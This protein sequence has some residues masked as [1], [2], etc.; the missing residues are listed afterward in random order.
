MPAQLDIRIVAH[1]AASGVL[2]RIGGVVD[3]LGRFGLAAAGLRQIGDA[4]DGLTVGVKAA[5]DLQQAVANISTIKPE[6]D[7]TAVFGALN[8]MSTRVPQSSA[9][10]GESLYNVFSSMSVSSQEALALVETFAQGAVGAQ[11]D[12]ATFGTSIMGVLNAY[13]LAASDAARVSD[14]FFNTVNAG[15]VTGQELA[16]SL[17]PVTQAAKSAGMSVDELGGFIAGVT[18]EGGPAAQNINNLSNF[19]QKL[20]TKEAQKQLNELGVQTVDATGKFRPTTDVLE[21]LKGKLGGMTEAAKANALQAIFPDA[22]AR[23]GAQTLLSQ[24]EFVRGAIETNV[25]QAG[26]ASSAYATMAAT[27]NSQTQL[28]TNTLMSIAVTVGAQVLPAVTPLVS[29]FAAALPGAFAATSAALAPLGAVLSTLAQYLLVVVQ[30][31]DYLN[32]F[33]ADLPASV[34]PVVQLLGQGLAGAIEVLP[35][36]FA[37]L[38]DVGGQVAGFLGEH[39]ELIAGVVAAW[40]TFGVLSTVVGWI[41]SAVA[42]WGA[43]SV[44]VTAAGGV[45]AAIVAVLGGPITVAVLAVAAVV[46]VLTAAWIGNWGDIQG[47]TAAVVEFLGALPETLVGYWD[48]IVGGVQGLVDGVTGAWDAVSE[49]TT[50][51]W[52]AI[53]AFLAE[54]WDVLLAT[55]IGGP[56]GLL[57]ALIARNWDTIAEATSAAW[58]AIQDALR[59]VWE[60]IPADIRAD[61]ELILSTLIER[62]AAWVE[63]VVATGRAMW[64]AITGTLAEIVTAVTTWAT[65]TFLAPIQ[66]LVGTATSAALEVGQGIWTSVTTKLAEVV[67]A[68]TTWATSTFVAPI[69]GLIGTATSTAE[70]VGS[71][72]L[73]AIQGKLAEVV[74]AV[75]GWVGAVL[76]AIQ[77][78]VGS[79]TGAASEVGQGII[80]GISG[81]IQAGAGAIRSLLYNLARSALDAAKEALGIESPSK[82]FAAEVGRP[83]VQGVMAGLDQ[84]ASPL[85][86]RLGGLVGVPRFGPGL[87]A[88]GGGRGG[89]VH[90]HVTVQGNVYRADEMREVVLNSIEELRRRRRWDG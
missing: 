21:D 8:E 64:D 7:T 57:V 50:A 14:V 88:A 81:A 34:Q 78:L 60:Q 15:V 55:V 24:L 56:I 54:W 16:T 86:A 39:V 75:T 80:S 83:I 63:S 43:M 84:M 48:A 37:A 4:A 51:A 46:G 79:A 35:P 31:G 2:G 68:V 89:D 77:G 61:L 29:A 28:L 1:D 23:Q 26:S 20:T 33:L 87:A 38:V 6:I 19:L 67:T 9:Q 62:G 5:G 85:E 76:G 18:K 58:T 11:T 66:G 74:T 53:G 36:L 17:G 13:G 65:S 12:A 49:A 72:I 3:G 45:M 30:E 47:K 69:A 59:A 70:S 82:V 40:A 10:L 32:D 71:G 42:A 44:A 52:D 73:S 90:V 22:Q 27:F 25:A 41:M